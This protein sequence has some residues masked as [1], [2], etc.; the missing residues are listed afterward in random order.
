MPMS[1]VQRHT[2]KFNSHEQDEL[3]VLRKFDDVLETCKEQ[4]SSK[5]HQAPLD[6]KPA[7][8]I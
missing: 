6:A 8:G 1:L 7:D 2:I 3:V 4:G 5:Q